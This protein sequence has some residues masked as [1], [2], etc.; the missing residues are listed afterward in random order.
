M[1]PAATTSSETIILWAI[2]DEPLFRHGL[3]QLF[4]RQ[5]RVTCEHLFARC[6]EALQAL[7]EEPAPDVVLIDVGLPGI[8]GIEGIRRIKSLSPITDCIVL[9]IH[10]ENDNVFKAI[11]A[12]ASGY[13]LKSVAAD[14]I[15]NAVIEVRHGGAPI[16]PQIARNVLSMFSRLHAPASEYG[17]SEREK[18]ILGHLVEG[19]TKRAISERV[20]LSHHT[21]DSH[22]RNIYAK[23]HVH[24]RSGAIAKALNERIL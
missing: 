17:L 23:L 6:E 14:E 10:E 22:I 20:L 15:V 7:E 12:G 5:S 9:T 2:E 16:N 18:E 24:S 19:L 4:R 13:L 21:I 3:E 11:C 1:T 8:S